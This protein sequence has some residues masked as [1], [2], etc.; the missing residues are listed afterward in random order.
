MNVL[1]VRTSAMGDVVH[2]LPVL[3]ALRRQRPEARIAWAIEEGFAPLLAGH[4]D[5]DR[6]IP[7]R[8][9]QDRRRPWRAAAEWRRV[10]RRLR[11]FDADVALD[12]MGNHKGALLAR[13][14]GARRVIGAARDQRRE[15]A[16]ARWLNE[17]V[18]TGGVHAVDRGLALLGA[19]G[20]E[21]QPADFAGDKLLPAAVADADPPYAVVQAGA[22]WGNK[23]Y[24]PVW[25]GRVA[26][27]L[28]RRTGL[29][30]R[31]PIAP[32][33]EELAAAV[34]AASDGA[35]RAVDAGPLPRLVAL[36]RGARLVLG[37]DTG[38]LHLAH[39]LGV[40]VLCLMGPTDPRRN[41]PYGA[42]ERA[43]WRQ[44][45]CSFCYKRLVDAKACLLTIPPDDVVA[46]ACA[47]LA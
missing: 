39:A 23:R 27:A 16:S 33:E 15:P 28:A 9:R 12:L 20:L 31:V 18:A 19:L 22:G 25:W 42:P 41:G 10:R 13:L 21:P 36:L 1:L 17:T 3:T 40:S 47:L 6:L 44:L 2:A 34:A 37:G 32:G 38:P 30:I 11:A 35:A 46:R 8:L 4:A 5:L 7:V 45:P 43:L 24:P 14:S 29:E 26:R